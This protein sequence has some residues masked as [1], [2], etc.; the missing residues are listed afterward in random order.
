MRE[1]YVRL[2]RAR[3]RNGGKLASFRSGVRIARWLAGEL[4]K[5]GFPQPEDGAGVLVGCSGGVCGSKPGLHGGSLPGDGVR[6][7]RLRVV[8][9][10]LRAAAPPRGRRMRTAEEDTEFRHFYRLFGD[11][12]VFARPLRNRAPAGGT[13]LIDVSGS[14]ALT[15]VHIDGIIAAVQAA[16][17]VAMYSG[18]GDRG[19]LRVVV[20]N[21]RRAAPRDLEPYGGGNIVDLPALEWLARQP[22]PRVW[23]SDGYVTGCGDIT[24]DALKKR[25]R[26]ICAEAGI[27]HVPD[28]A[29]AA[30]ALH[31][32][33][34]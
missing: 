3:A 28:A 21:G 11:R 16:T 14:M 34:R 5:R 8:E 33:Q 1:T 12:R 26:E 24:T 20:R 22:A 9:P 23:I 30:K 17:L 15:A 27:V 31:Q 7:G 6:P 32:R 4:G 25:C 19:E 13:V 2:E 18:S 10:P 29:G